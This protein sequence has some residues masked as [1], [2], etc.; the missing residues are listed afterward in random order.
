MLDRHGWAFLFLCDESAD[1]LEDG[2]VYFGVD[3]DKYRLAVL[4]RGFEL[5]LLYGCD[6]TLVEALFYAAK[7]SDVGRGAIGVDP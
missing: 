2:E 3:L 5:V 6:G 7:D 1:E 4:H